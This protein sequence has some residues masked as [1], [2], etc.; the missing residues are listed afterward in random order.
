[1]RLFSGHDTPIA[2]LLNTWGV[3]NNLIPPFASTLFMEMHRKPEEGEPPAK[4]YIE[5]SSVF[6]K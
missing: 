6:L 3:Y 2:G 5:V 1:M 4:S